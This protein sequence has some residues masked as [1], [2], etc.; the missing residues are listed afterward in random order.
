MSVIVA[1]NFCLSICDALQQRAVS[2]KVD[3]RVGAKFIELRFFVCPFHIVE[4]LLCAHPCIY[5]C[6][7]NTAAIIAT[8]KRF[9]VKLDFADLRVEIFIDV[10]LAVVKDACRNPK[11]IFDRKF[12][13][14]V[15]ILLVDL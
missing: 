9:E 2:V 5:L 1:I 6:K 14:C 8:T 13:S 3:L 15:K 10:C 12:I 11:P 4:V 7:G